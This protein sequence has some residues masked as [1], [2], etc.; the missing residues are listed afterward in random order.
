MSN[1]TIFYIATLDIAIHIAGSTTTVS[2]A[3]L[4]F[5]AVRMVFIEEG[6]L[7]MLLLNQPVQMF[8]NN[9][10]TYFS[11]SSC[12]LIH[13]VHL[14]LKCCTLV[15]KCAAGVSFAVFFAEVSL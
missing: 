3:L 6:R 1:I 8:Y 15:C 11:P 14:G 5:P 7:K 4:L 2:S 9:E 10:K 13:F 12:S